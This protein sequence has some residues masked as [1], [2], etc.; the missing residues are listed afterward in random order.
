M[1]KKISLKILDCTLRDGGYYTNWNFSKKIISE[2]IS[3]INRSN[4]DVVE[5][6]FR[7]LNKNNHGV[8]ANSNENLIK[9]L[10]IK[11]NLK[12]GVMINSSDFNNE[13]NCKNQIN[14]FFLNKSKTKISLIRLATHAKDI[15]KIIPRIIY[16]KK[17]G[18]EIA[19]N[20]MQIDKIKE[21]SLIKILKLLKR[22]KSVDVFYFADSFGNLNPLKVQS[23]C[24]IIKKNWYKNFGFHAHDNCGLSLQNC[25]AAIK[26][27]AKWIDS[28]IQGM[29][30][31][32]GNVSTEELISF[33][34][35]NYITK[36]DPKPIY[37][38]AEEVFKSLK[39]KYGWGKSIYYYLS[40][41]KNIHPSYIQELL[42]DKRYNHNEVIEIIDELA[43]TKSSAYNPSTLKLLINENI[44]LK[45]NW[46]AKNWCNKQNVLILGQGKSV[47][48][49]KEKI[50]SFIKKNKCKV[51]SLNI[52]KYLEKKFI[53]YYVACHETRVIV[54]LKKYS[55]VSKKL[56]LP[57]DRFK[58]IINKK[59]FKKNIKNYGMIVKKNKLSH[60]NKYCELP[61][62]LAIGYALCIV[63]AGNAKNIF[64]AG[65][66]GFR[67][68]KLLNIEM[69]DYLK[70]IHKKNPNLKLKSLTPVNYKI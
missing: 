45:N 34:T 47:E 11:K 10:P 26:N 14:K 12:I 59:K 30:R 66:D 13:L 61:K 62:N 24:K 49:K 9:S 56:I 35:E 57:L 25:I 44:T 22:T 64:L 38:L 40:A 39:I 29:G 46:N 15:E 18:Y 1:K 42:V 16:L 70:F 5:V 3:N 19:V 63:L 27:G 7:F 6:G 48:A 41:K 52:N 67:N 4:I 55:D 50:L 54:D 69:S 20:L 32:A 58:N 65:F 33:V 36:Y 53:D 21:K 2:Y 31:G 60:Y 8:F 43:K 28:T 51:I 17:L 23:I 37:Y 68:Q